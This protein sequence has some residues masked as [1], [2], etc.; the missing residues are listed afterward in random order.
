MKRPLISLITVLSATA[1]GIFV[2]ANLAGAFAETTAGS[3]SDATAVGAAIGVGLFLPHVL[4]VWLGV[5]LNWIGYAV[6]M[7]GL[8][9]TAA[10]L[11]TVAAFLGFFYIIFM[12]PVIVL[13]FVAFAKERSNKAS[14]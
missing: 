2:V 7:P 14:A 5:L 8:T 9:L 1:Y 12:I 13:A 10:I 11:Y 4:L 3:T 6:R